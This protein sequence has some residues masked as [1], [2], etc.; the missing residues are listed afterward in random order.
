MQEL[1]PIQLSWV[2]AE[3]ML[4]A[5]QSSGPTSHLCQQKVGYSV[6]VCVGGGVLLCD[7]L[8]LGPTSAPWVLLG[9]SMCRVAICGE[10]RKGPSA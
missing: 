5:S 7:L 2:L 3:E 8:C 1:T 4:R 9:A 10:K 6:C